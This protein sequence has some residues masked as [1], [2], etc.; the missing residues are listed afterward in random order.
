MFSRGQLW[1][2]PD[3]G[4]TWQAMWEILVQHPVHPEPLVVMHQEATYRPSEFGI[5]VPARIMFEWR[6]HF[7]HPKGGVPVFTVRERITY[8]YGAFRRFRVKAAMKVDP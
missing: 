2:D 1:L 4:Q 5:P 7:S 3:T 6:D 8:I